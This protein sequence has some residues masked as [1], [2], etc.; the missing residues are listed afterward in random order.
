MNHIANLRLF[1]LSP[2]GIECDANGLRVGDVALLARDDESAWVLRDQREL[3]RDLSR[4]YGFPVD[5]GPRRAGLAAIAKALRDRNIAKA[6]IATLLLQFPDPPTLAGGCVVKL[7]RDRLAR[8][9]VACRLLKA[10]GDWEEKHPRTGSPPNAGWFAPKPAGAEESETPE[11]APH[12]GDVGYVQGSGAAIEYIADNSGFHNEFRD[13]LITDV[14]A[15]G[16]QC[17]KEFN[18]DFDGVNIFVDI[19]CRNR[20]G[21]LTGVEIKTVITDYTVNQKIVYP[22][23]ILGA[24]V[25]SNDAR[26]VNF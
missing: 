1:R 17:F 11:K 20:F 9:L 13:K 12:L 7:N 4:A 26:I 19:L 15:A 25:V 14:N 6:Q 3:N 23:V 5:V 24:G 10:D 8:D 2:D 18:L 22:H 16:N 21:V